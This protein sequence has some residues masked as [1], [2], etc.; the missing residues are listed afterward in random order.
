MNDDLYIVATLIR[1]L[2]NAFFRHWNSI[3]VKHPFQMSLYIIKNALSYNN[4]ASKAGSILYGGL[5]DRCTFNPF[6]EYYNTVKYSTPVLVYDIKNIA[7]TLHRSIYL[8]TITN[9]ELDSIII[10]PTTSCMF[11]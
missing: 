5:L 11:L 8:Q 10:I 9:I 1:Q 4:T 6:L 2:L 7:N 3:I